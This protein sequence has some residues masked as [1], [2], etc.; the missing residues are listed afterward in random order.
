MSPLKGQ[1]PGHLGQ[2]TPTRTKKERGVQSTNNNKAPVDYGTLAALHTPGTCHPSNDNDDNNDVTIMANQHTRY[3]MAL[4]A[5]TAYRQTDTRER[6]FGKNYQM[7][8]K[9]PK[10]DVNKL[11]FLPVWHPCAHTES[12][13]ILMRKS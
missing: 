6:I 4:R 11:L 3:T 10:H 12:D 8:G 1:S 7:S 13:S 9:K 5:Y 2:R